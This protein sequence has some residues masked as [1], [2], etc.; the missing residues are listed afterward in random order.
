MDFGL[1][2][3]CV[4]S[5]Y[6]QNWIGSLP[7]SPSWSD[8]PLAPLP[9]L[10][11]GTVCTLASSF[12]EILD[13]LSSAQ[14]ASSM[15]PIGM[16]F[17]LRKMEFVDMTESGM[18]HN[19]QDCR[20]PF[21][22]VMD[23]VPNSWECQFVYSLWKNITSQ[24]QS[25]QTQSNIYNSV[26]CPNLSLSYDHRLKHRL[27]F[28]EIYMFMISQHLGIFLDSTKFWFCCRQMFECSAQFRWLYTSL[29]TPHWPLAP[30]ETSPTN[31]GICT[32]RCLEWGCWVCNGRKRRSGIDIYVLICC[33]L[34]DWYSH[35]FFRESF[36]FLKLTRLWLRWN[37]LNYG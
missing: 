14:S 20:F 34:S 21:W 2:V 16:Q 23:W 36:F 30:K 12:V 10:V 17:M 18:L 35:P 31:K 32:E 26:H 33:S 28:W 5:S 8:S 13:F 11:H 4:H 3:C 7:S 15:T 25:S 37:S 22:Q 1:F 19:N 24:K 29:C 6:P 27:V 9:N